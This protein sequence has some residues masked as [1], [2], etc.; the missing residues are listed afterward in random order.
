MT[1]PW[2][3]TTDAFWLLVFTVVVGIL[4]LLIYLNDLRK[5]ESKERGE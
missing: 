3:F 4:P 5:P 2:G 1:G